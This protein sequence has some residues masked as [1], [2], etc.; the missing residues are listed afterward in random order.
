MYHELAHDI[1][2]VDD[3]EKKPSNEGKL[4]YPEISSYKKKKM[5]EFIESFHS[6]FEQQ[7]NK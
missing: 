4:M 3:L 7:T 1:L 2:N 5:D 6:L